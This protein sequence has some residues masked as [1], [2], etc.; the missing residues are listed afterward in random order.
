MTLSMCWADFTV[1]FGALSGFTSQLQSRTN[2]FG[3]IAHNANPHSHP[4]AIG[5]PKP[6]AIILN[7]QQNAIIDLLKINRHLTGPAMLDGIYHGLLRDIIDMHRQGVIQL[8][9][10]SIAAKITLD[11]VKAAGAVGKLLK[12]R[13]QAFGLQ[14]H[15]EQPPRY[16]AS[17]HK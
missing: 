7:G 3:S 16:S 6:N 8:G 11:L 14:S 5:Q 15:W 9:N 12:R 13:N 4:F 17:L 1:N 2:Y 10:C